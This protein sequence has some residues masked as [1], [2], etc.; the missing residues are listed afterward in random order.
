MMPRPGQHLNGAH[1]PT[2]GIE[3]HKTELDLVECGRRLSKVQ[4]QLEKVKLFWVEVIGSN[5]EEDH[6]K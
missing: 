1:W 6:L 2:L 5:G 4:K 3:K